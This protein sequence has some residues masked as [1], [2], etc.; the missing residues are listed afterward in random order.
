MMHD[1]LIG[2]A[3]LAM[4]IFPAIIAALPKKDNEDDA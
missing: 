2:L 3:F 1:V 4:I